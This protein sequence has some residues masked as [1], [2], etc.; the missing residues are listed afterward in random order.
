[1]NPKVSKQQLKIIDA[2]RAGAWIWTAGEGEQ[3]SAYLTY[4][5]GPENATA[6]S[7]LH[8]RTFKALK[9]AGIIEVAGPRHWTLSAEFAQQPSVQ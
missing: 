5:A 9:D 3:E 2:M 4:A 1:M 7:P 6:S 8:K